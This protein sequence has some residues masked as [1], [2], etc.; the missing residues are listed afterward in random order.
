[1]HELIDRWCDEH[2]GNG[3]VTGSHLCLYGEIHTLP[4]I[5]LLPPF[6][7]VLIRLG[8]FGFRPSLSPQAAG[9]DWI[10][11]HS[12][13]L[14]SPFSIV[15]RP[16]LHLCM[17]AMPSLLYNDNIVLP[18]YSEHHPHAAVTI[19]LIH[20][21]M[22]CGD[23]DWKDAIPCLVDYHLL[24]PDLPGHGSARQPDAHP[25][26][27][28]FS[29]DA[30]A[31]TLSL[32]IRKKAKAGRAHIV[33]FSLG[34]HVAMHLVPR[35]PELVLGVFLTG[36]NVFPSVNARFLASLFWFQHRCQAAVSRIASSHTATLPSARPPDTSFAAWRCIA[37]TLCNDELSYLGRPE[38]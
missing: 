30:A 5:S 27:S 31:A 16:L 10:R 38:H 8:C 35:Q 24:V 2:S 13:I 11:V 32:L 33:A 17:T 1:M 29:L 12:H 7:A 36:Y 18:P 20:G 3:T 19:V 25:S 23:D 15:R 28:T 9:I 21:G 6:R 34:S 37:D 26:I 4:S 14:M 22:S